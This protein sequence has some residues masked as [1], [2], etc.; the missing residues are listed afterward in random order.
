MHHVQ[1]QFFFK[2]LVN[3]ISNIS[4]I[5]WNNSLRIKFINNSRKNTS[6]V[7]KVSEKFNA[8]TT[9]YKLK[10]KI[11]TLPNQIKLSKTTDAHM[12]NHVKIFQ[13]ID[14]P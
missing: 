10:E 1:K 8:A 12:E 3:W 11:V 7:K 5:S 4:C 14:S 9:K 6:A 13:F 2:G